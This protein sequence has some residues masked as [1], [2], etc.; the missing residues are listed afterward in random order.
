MLD[1]LKNIGKIFT[2]KRIYVT[3][4]TMLLNAVIKTVNMDTI[5]KC[6]FMCCITAI[7]ISY[8]VCETIRKS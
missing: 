5:T 3:A 4:G 8:I 7:A 1:S 6:V 2:S